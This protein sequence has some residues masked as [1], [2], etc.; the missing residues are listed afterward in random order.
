MNFV[1]A[2]NTLI[3][4][5]KWVHG[6]LRRGKKMTIIAF[7]ALPP[8]SLDSLLLTSSCDKFCANKRTETYPVTMKR[9]GILTRTH[10]VKLQPI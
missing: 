1:I 3:M 8:E 10:R 5:L 4:M 9:N 6:K 2:T 7:F